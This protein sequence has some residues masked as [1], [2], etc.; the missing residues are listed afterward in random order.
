MVDSYQLQDYEVAIR[1]WR[2]WQSQCNLTY[3]VSC[4]SCVR[5][6]FESPGRSQRQKRHTK[7]K[8]YVSDVDFSH[9]KADYLEIVRQ[10]V[11]TRLVVDPVSPARASCQ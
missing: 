9:E 10:V 3:E 6:H 1:C 8:C 7:R 4:K 5:M 2:T 11:M